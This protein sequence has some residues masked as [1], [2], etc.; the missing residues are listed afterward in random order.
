VTVSRSS[1]ARCREPFRQPLTDQARYDVRAAA[2][3]KP[4]NDAHWPAD[5]GEP[6]A[7][8]VARERAISRVANGAVCCGA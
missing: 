3:R 5:L 4:N 7:I 2:R 6:N 8:G 1:A